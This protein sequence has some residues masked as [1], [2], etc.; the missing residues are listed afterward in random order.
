MIVKCHFNVNPFSNINTTYLFNYFFGEGIVK[1][2]QIKI[3]FWFTPS[4]QYGIEHLYDV[5]Y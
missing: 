1:K 3:R 2:S 4:K 5:L